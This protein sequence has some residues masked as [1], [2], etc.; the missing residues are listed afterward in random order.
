MAST[1]RFLLSQDGPG[2]MRFGGSRVAFIDLDSGF[3]GLRE[4]M[5]ALIGR[6]LT[7]S[8]MQQ[9]GANGGAAFAK[10]FVARMAE[11]DGARAL[12]DCVAA[13]QAAGFGE[14]SIEQLDWPVGRVL[15]RGNN[16]FEAWWVRR[17]SSSSIFT[18]R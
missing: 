3:W 7:A 8:M 17:K 18:P 1:D 5:E 15:V 11:E 12:R 2:V 14:F 13:Y 10:S 16:A 4:H 6:P 9:A